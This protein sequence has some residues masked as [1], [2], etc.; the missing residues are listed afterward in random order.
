MLTLLTPTGARPVA[1]ALCERWMVAQDYTGPVRWL[2]VDDGPEPQPVT[3]ARDGWVVEVVRPAPAWREGKNTQARNL[4][5]GLA[6]CR[7]TDHVVVI[8]DD[9]HYAPNWL[10]HVAGELERAQLVGERRSRY[11]NLA[12]R[13]GREMGNTAHASLCSTAV[14][15]RAVD[16]LRR[17]CRHGRGIDMHLWRTFTDR[18]LFDGRRVTGIKGLPGR[19]GIGIGHSRT[20]E[21]TADPDGALLRQWIGDAAEA[22]L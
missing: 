16:A 2:V 10:R 14:R 17:S 7:A 5:A 4:L 20:F 13:Q 19:G 15:G 9:D 12:T 11:Y 22:Y 6:Y 21:G 3:L 18:H 8:E 1:F